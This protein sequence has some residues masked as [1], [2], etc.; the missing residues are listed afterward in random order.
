MIS[1]SCFRDCATPTNNA[2]DAG[3]YTTWCIVLHAETVAT[4]AIHRL[5]KPAADSRDIAT[6]PR[7][8]ITYRAIV[9][10]MF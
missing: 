4:V 6:K 7:C 10:E 9:M 3:V 2:V 1:F 8:R 5:Y